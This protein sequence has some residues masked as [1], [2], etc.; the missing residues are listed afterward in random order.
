MVQ[1]EKGTMEHSNNETKE[2]WNNGT[3]RMEQWNNGTG[4]M[5]EWNNGT[6]ELEQ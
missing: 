4:T 6:M 5:E 2:Q 1:C 3:G